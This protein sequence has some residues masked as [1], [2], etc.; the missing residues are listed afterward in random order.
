MVCH[1]ET[2]LEGYVY[3]DFDENNNFK[4]PKYLCGRV[5]LSSTNDAIQHSNINMVKQLEDGIQWVKSVDECMNDDNKKIFDSKQLNKIEASGIPPFCL[6]LKKN[7]CIILI[8]NLNVK[9][10][11]VNGTQCI[12]EEI[13]SHVIKA[14]L[15]DGGKHP[16][17]FISK[18]SIVCS[19]TDFP[20]RFKRKQFPILLA[21][22]L[23]FN[24][25]QG[26]S[27]ERVG[28]RLHQSVFTHGLL[29]I[30]M[31]RCGDPMFV[32]VYADQSEF[33]HLI[34]NGILDPTKTYTRNIVFPE[35]FEQDDDELL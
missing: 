14:R 23:T 20:T 15:L 10:R 8:C 33:Q 16:E 35:I 13:K 6:S 19:D 31:S 7:V 32:F 27:L 1:D 9:P 5:I 29:Y 17:I 21:Y 18:I 11:H 26:Q 3:T 25:A 34:D 28:I 30:G 24:R 22:Y 2:Q 4:N 12:I